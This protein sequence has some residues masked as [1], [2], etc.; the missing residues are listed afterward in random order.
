VAF[1][2]KAVGAHYGLRD[3]SLWIVGREQFKDLSDRMYRFDRLSYGAVA[4][5]NCLKSSNAS[6]GLSYMTFA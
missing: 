1:L 6:N 5:M 2:G 3:A 4:P